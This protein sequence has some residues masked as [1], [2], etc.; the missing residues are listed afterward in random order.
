[1]ADVRPFRAVRY[2]RPSAEV[3]A[4]PYDVLDE[5]QRLALRARDPHN[6]V[7]LTADPDEAAAGRRFRSWLAEGV[8]VRD[9]T[10]AV[11]LL[12]QDVPSLEGVASRR[13]GIAASLR[14]VP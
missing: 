3:T 11:W 2:A 9:G 4:P 5:P 14:V 8:L 6:V 1:M 12:E 10:S 13:A 7:H